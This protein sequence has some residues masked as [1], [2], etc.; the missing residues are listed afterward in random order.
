[1]SGSKP[2]DYEH[3]RL[4]ISDCMF[5]LS[6]NHSAG[7]CPIRHAVHLGDLG[8]VSSICKICGDASHVENYCSAVPGA[9]FR[10]RCCGSPD[11]RRMQCPWRR[12]GPEAQCRH[13]HLAGHGIIDCPLRAPS[14][15]EKGFA[16][17][18]NRCTFC[19]QGSHTLA[20]CVV[21]ATYQEVID[22][23][24]SK[25]EVVDDDDA[26]AE[27]KAPPVQRDYPPRRCRL[28]SGAGSHWHPIVFDWPTVMAD[29]LLVLDA[30]LNTCG[31]SGLA[32]TDFSL[33][34]K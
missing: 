33:G 12:A 13:C 10:C 14:L 31:I 11:H 16:S 25:V 19:M 5:C 4:L 32:G 3:R 9:E 22:Q 7:C 24:S 26:T 34:S 1:M 29:M 21:H 17:Q 30:N 18:H 27:T 2:C 8:N 28:S 20:G 23:E 6:P 15:A